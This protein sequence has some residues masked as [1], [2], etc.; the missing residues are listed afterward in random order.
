MTP[1]LPASASP[2]VQSVLN[3]NYDEIIK[4][5]YPLFKKT[6]LNYFDCIRYYDSGE[7][8]LFS[9]CPDFSYQTSMGCLY[10]TLEE[11]KAFVGFGLKYT[12][13]T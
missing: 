1:V 6:P 11:L 5:C 4:I 13:L 3:S 2:I 10:P 9:T 12:F 8:T 7:M